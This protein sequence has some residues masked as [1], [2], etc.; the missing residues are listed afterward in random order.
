MQGNDESMLIGIINMHHLM[1]YS[2]FVFVLKFLY[3]KQIILVAIYCSEL[4]VGV[5]VLLLDI[6]FSLWLRDGMGK[7]AKVFECK[8]F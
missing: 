4:G 6:F 7:R 3:A 8:L 2:P 1:V 5:V